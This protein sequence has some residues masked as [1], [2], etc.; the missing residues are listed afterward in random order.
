[1]TMHDDEQ[2]LNSLRSV[3]MPPADR[4]ALRHVLAAYARTYRPQPAAF[5][6]F[7]R[8]AAAFSALVLLLLAAGVTAVTAHDALPGNP[9]YALRASVEDRVVLALASDD[10]ARLDAELRQI[11]RALTDEQRALDA[12]SVL[13]EEPAATPA[14]VRFSDDAEREVRQLEEE[15]RDIEG[16]DVPEL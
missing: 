2:L 1:M 10:D 11:E 15:L 6:F 13:D 16:D 7:L 9:L 8:H 4:E 14:E 3:R 12:E 5:A